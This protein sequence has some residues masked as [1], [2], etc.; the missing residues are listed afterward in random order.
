MSE[1]LIALI[2]LTIFASYPIFTEFI[3]PYIEDWMMEMM[4]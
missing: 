1:I 3:Y 4:K 2:V